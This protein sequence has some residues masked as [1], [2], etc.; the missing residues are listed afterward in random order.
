MTRKHVY[1]ACL[2]FVVLTLA[3][4]GMGYRAKQDIEAVAT[5]Q[6]NHQQLLLAQKVAADIMDHFSFLRT[7]LISFAPL[8]SADATSPA[9]VAPPFFDLLAPWN[10]VAL[11]L[12]RPEQTM[13][14]FFDAGGR[15]L[16]TP[17][18][19]P[20]P[21]FAQPASPA[22]TG[23]VTISR[24]FS[25]ANGPLAGRRLVAMTLPLARNGHAAGGLVLLVDAEAV[26]ARYA[27]DVRS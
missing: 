22:P 26:A 1:A 6:F 2:A 20:T 19:C 11:G 12:A 15:V 17:G 7:C 8:W 3:I 23:R 5:E 10:V 25:P 4:A 18:L 13:P 14:T 9:L 16:A 21:C 27:H 24:V